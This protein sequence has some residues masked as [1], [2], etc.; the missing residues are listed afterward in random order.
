MD[1][2]LFGIQ[3]SGKGTLARSAVSKYKTNYFETGEELRKLSKENSKLGEKIKKIV[4]EGNLVQNEIVMEIIENYIN[5]IDKNKPII[6]DGIPRFME[7]AISLESLFKKYNRD[8]IGILVEIPEEMAIERIIKRRICPNCKSIY[9]I[10]Y[11]KNV[12]KKCNTELIIREDDNPKSIKKRLEKYKEETIP[13]IEYFKKK[14]KLKIMDG[15]PKIIEAR[16]NLF[17]II[18]KIIKK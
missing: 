14:N 8:Y 6:I 5:K 16:K 11:T 15:T 1:I 17:K 7:Q 3:G 12:C 4:N 10:T 2:I 13:V 18:D 9:P